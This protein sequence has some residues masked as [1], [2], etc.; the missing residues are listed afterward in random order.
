MCEI[1]GGAPYIHP[2]C[3]ICVQ[4]AILLRKATLRFALLRNLREKAAKAAE[5]QL[6]LPGGFAPI[7]FAKLA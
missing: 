5:M 4:S 6:K 2:F 1:R 3:T 7:C